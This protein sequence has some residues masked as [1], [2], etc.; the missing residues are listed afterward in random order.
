MPYNNVV[1]CM[2]R[3][4]RVRRLMNAVWRLVRTFWSKK[5]CRHIRTFSKVLKLMA[6]FI[7]SESSYITSCPLNEFA[8]RFS[9]N[10]GLLVHII[11]HDISFLT[12]NIWCR[13]KHQCLFFL[14]AS[15]NWN[16]F[17]L[18]PLLSYWSKIPGPSRFVEYYV[19]HGVDQDFCDFSPALRLHTKQNSFCPRNL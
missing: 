6:L 4:R 16:S 11:F 17:P 5:K 18:L 9:R 14:S 7:Y 2:T 15:S 19:F 13:K 10:L 8:G 3:V 1:N 12:S